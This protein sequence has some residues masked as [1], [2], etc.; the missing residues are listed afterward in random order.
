VGVMFLAH[1]KTNLFG[2]KL[3]NFA[4]EGTRKREQRDITQE[5]SQLFPWETGE[6]A[7]FLGKKWQETK[8]E[9]KI[10]EK[11]AWNAYP[12]FRKR[13][14]MGCG[15]PRGKGKSLC[16]F[17]FLPRTVN[18]IMAQPRTRRVSP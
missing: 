6:A 7:C 16:V 14:S 9:A 18:A 4:R 12:T 5:R 11:E 8:R 13:A 10:W 15:G 17:L 1:G 2:L 3:R